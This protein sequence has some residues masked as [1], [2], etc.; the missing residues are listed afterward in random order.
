MI[1]D[2]N[3][4]IVGVSIIIKLKG[5]EKNYN[6]EYCKTALIDGFLRNFNNYI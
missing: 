3:N 5:R 4:N 2:M 6:I 1:S